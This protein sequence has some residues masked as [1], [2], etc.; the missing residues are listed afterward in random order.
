M[1]WEPVIR[2]SVTVSPAGMIK[3]ASICRKFAS[4]VGF[5]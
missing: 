1:P 2:P 5:S 4:G 3:I